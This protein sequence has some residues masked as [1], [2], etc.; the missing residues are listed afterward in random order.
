[1]SYNPTKFA[2]VW[3]VDA[4]VGYQDGEMINV[5]FSN[6]EWTS[7]EGTKGEGALVYSPNRQGTISITL[8]A[9]SP[10]N[11]KWSLAYQAKIPLPFTVIDRSSTKAVFFTPK[12]MPTKQPDISRSRDQ[13]LVTWTLTFVNGNAEHIGS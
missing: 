11:G 12:A 3:G 4:A 7:Y 10:T 8:Q 2:A 9:D 5:S 1:M 13:P 6:D